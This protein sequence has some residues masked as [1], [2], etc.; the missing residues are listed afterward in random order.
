MA[1]LPGRP[2]CLRLILPLL[3]A[4]AEAREDLLDEVGG[5]G[6]AGDFSESANGLAGSDAGEV[7]GEVGGVEGGEGLFDGL[8]CL[9][10]QGVMAI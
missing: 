8:A 5:G 4:D 3:F 1:I 2:Y 10:E 9:L 6:F 7:V